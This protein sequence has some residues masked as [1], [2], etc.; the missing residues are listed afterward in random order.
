MP[1]KAGAPKRPGL[2]GPGGRPNAQAPVKK[3]APQRTFSG[4]PIFDQIPD[5]DNL[6]RQTFVPSQVPY[7]QHFFF[8]HGTNKL[9]H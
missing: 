7:S 1:K 2:S 5:S 4:P 3:Y 9:E 6:K 8:I